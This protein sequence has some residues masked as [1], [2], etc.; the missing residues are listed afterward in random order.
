MPDAGRIVLEIACGSIH[1]A[2]LADQAGAD[3]LELCCAMELDGLTPSLGTACEVAAV[4]DTPFVAMVR[5][6]AG[7]FLWSKSE[8]SVM[9]RDASL[10]L[11]A[12]ASG[13]V[14][15]CLTSGSDV[16][17]RACRRIMRA[18]GRNETVFHPVETVFH[19]AFD[20]VRDQRSALDALIDLGITRVLTS[21]GAPTALEG[22]AKI[23]ALVEQARGRIEIL[24]AGGIREHNVEAVVKQ[25]GCTQV[26]LSRR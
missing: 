26:H 5:P 3:R 6:R 19:R 21:G 13:V 4:L 14:F 24:P 11:E 20:Q 12:G 16:D 9:E 15:G 1:D 2:V 23:R 10:L 18:T 8:L 17:V 22:V 7:H 25:T